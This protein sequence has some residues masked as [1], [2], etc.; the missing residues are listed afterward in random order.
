MSQSMLSL[1]N[2]SSVVV[3]GFPRNSCLSEDVFGISSIDDT[4]FLQMK[5]KILE[6]DLEKARVTD[7]CGD[8]AKCRR[9]TGTEN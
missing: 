5:F 4:K 7:K 9:Y 6:T 2:V 1:K 3:C 8:T